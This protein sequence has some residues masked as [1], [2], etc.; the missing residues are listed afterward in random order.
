MRRY[1]YLVVM[2]AI[3]SLLTALTVGVASAAGAVLTAGSGG[4]DVAVG[5]TITANLA[6]GTAADFNN[7]ATGTQGVHCAVS[8]TSAT[9]TANPAA[10]GTATE[11]LDVQSFSS[12]TTNIS[13]TNNNPAPTVTVDN[14]PFNASV[15]S[16]GALTVSGGASG[17]LQ[18]TL[19]IQTALGNITCVFQATAI[20]GTASNTDNSL[21]FSAQPFSKSSGSGLCPSS[22]FFTA[23]YS[24]VLD[25]TQADQPVFVN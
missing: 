20:S 2:A 18:T 16:T 25:H 7:S 21:R 22:G 4:P 14:L 12:C 11:S 24:P 6:P 17:P 13:G 15:D 19:H 9:V 5:D 1:L 8:S 10:P 3:A 23:T